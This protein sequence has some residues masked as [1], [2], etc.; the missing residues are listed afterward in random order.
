MGLAII[1]LPV[2]LAFSFWLTTS[3]KVMY[4]F[5]ILG[6]LWLLFSAVYATW[7]VYSF[8]PVSYPYFDNMFYLDALNLLV[9]DTV[10]LI[11]FLACLY[12]V[13]YLEEIA[14]RSN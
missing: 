5:N 3:R 2:I 1:G 14:P 11:S 13:G 4:A 7:T 6:A 8:G 12:S 9:L 10:L